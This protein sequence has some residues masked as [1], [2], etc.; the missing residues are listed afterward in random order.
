MAEVLVTGANGFV[1]SHI[2]EA[3]LTNGYTVRALVRKTS[4]LSNIKTLPLNLVYGDICY[5]E[6]LPAAVSGVTAVINNAGLVK[7]RNPEEFHRVNCEGTKNIIEAVRRHKPGLT[8]LIHISS[9]AACGPAPDDYPISEDHQP[10]P[11]T[12]YGRSKL[13][14]EQAILANKANVPST[15]LRPSAIYGPRDKEMYSF[16]KAIKLG[17]KPLFGD[18]ENYINFTYIKDFA[19]AVAKTIATP[20]VSG[21]I[22]FVAEKRAY[23]YR[24]A[25][26]IISSILI[27]K[28]ITLRIPGPILR[29]AGTV[30]DKVNGLIGKTSIFTRDKTN[31]ILSKYWLFDTSKIEQEMGFCATDFRTGAEETIAWYKEHDW[32]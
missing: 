1:G 7:T 28:T 24:E 3:L 10:N 19:Q 5:P 8:R 13:A 20:A 16:F 30:S 14:A 29:L 25:G 32:L 21:S 9:T 11:L 27:N 12:E 15:I 6:T 26:N 4:D 31:E 18:G 17:I 2:C 23:S 22:Y